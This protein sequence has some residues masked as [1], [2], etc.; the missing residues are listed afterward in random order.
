V[1]AD[2]VILATGSV[3]ANLRF[4]LDLFD[5]IDSTGALSWSGVPDSMLSWRRVI[6]V[7]LRS[8]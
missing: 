3:N 5:V 2:A 8:L 4:P 6:G 7:E 1:H